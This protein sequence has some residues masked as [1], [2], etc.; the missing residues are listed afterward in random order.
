MQK[1]CL[2]MQARNLIGSKPRP[3]S[4]ESDSER[5]TGKPA[6]TEARKETDSGP[7]VQARGV[8]DKRHQELHK[9][10]RWVNYFNDGNTEEVLSRLS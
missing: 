8:A 7:R 2:K 9:M 3:F 5:N 1:Q 4:H 6:Q 10:E